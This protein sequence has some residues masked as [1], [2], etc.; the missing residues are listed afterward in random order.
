M[1]KVVL[2]LLA[3]GGLYLIFANFNP[4]TLK[5]K[6]GLQVTTNDIPATLF[7]DDQYLDKTPF[8]D[9]KIQPKNYVLRIQPDD[10]TYAAYETP[11]KLNKGIVTIVNW[12]PGP[13]SASSG[14]VIYEME[15]LNTNDTQVELQTVP[16]GAIITF[17]Q[18]AKQFSPL[19]MTGITEGVHEFEVSLPSFKTQQHTV[20]V[21]KGHRVTITVIL[22]R[23][24]EVPTTVT[25]ANPEPS[26]TEQLS[27]NEPQVQILKTNFF[28]NEREVLRVRA[29]AS[30]AGA[31]LGF[32]PVGQRYHL[33]DELADWFQIEF[34]G[35]PG[36]VSAQFS[37]KIATGSTQ[38][39]Q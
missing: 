34:E 36:W 6:A 16:D 4:L 20:N 27:D 35:Q 11:I 13:T 29:T 39:N 31:E 17:D 3:V 14:G 5:Q 32:A 25:P 26:A 7:L 28:V 22:G 15:K 38:I 1:R 9:R 21:L 30:P 37:Q 19:L 8:I 2:L 18:G 24:D 23:L 12:K 33:I 10:A